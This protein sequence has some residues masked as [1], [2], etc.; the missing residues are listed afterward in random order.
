[1]AAPC[2]SMG[3]KVLSVI[4]VAF[5]VGAQAEDEFE[6][7]RTL[8]VEHSFDQGPAP[9]FSKRG[10][11]VIHS[12]K[13]NKA[14]FSQA[15]SLTPQERDRL[16]KLSKENGIYRLR[17]PL[18][19]GGNPEGDSY[20]STFTR[21]CAIYES[22]LRDRLMVNFD[23]TGEVLGVS[24]LPAAAACSGM[25]VS[26]ANLTSW[27]TSVEVVQTVAGPVPDTQTYI[28]KMKRDDQERSKGQQGDNRSFFGKYVSYLS[29]FC[30]V[31]FC[32]I[33]ARTC[34][35][36]LL[37]FSKTKIRIKLMCLSVRLQT[38]YVFL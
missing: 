34:Q 13:S 23:Q 38:G 8:Q 18:S 7:S 3:G 17:I 36:A 30:V 12:L 22:G 9:E 15:A 11:V 33:I 14:Q 32:L 24:V 25:E 16:E 29:L 1:M 26:A 4:F 35:K 10:T 31:L 28:D 6:G 20:V 21:A 27:K 19:K 37:N 5:L 2:V